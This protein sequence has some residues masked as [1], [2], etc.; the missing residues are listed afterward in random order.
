M[1]TADAERLHVG[2]KGFEFPHSIFTLQPTSLDL[3]RVEGPLQ[4]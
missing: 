2:M 3:Q 4:P 1:P